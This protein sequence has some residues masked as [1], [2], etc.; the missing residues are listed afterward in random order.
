MAF[1]QIVRIIQIHLVIT[2]EIC[3]WYLFV[4]FFTVICFLYIFYN[5]RFGMNGYSFLRLNGWRIS[6]RYDFEIF[7]TVSV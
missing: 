3:L 6:I 2:F 1:Y 7:S 5:N 4:I